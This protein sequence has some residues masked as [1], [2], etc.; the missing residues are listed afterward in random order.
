M[1]CI[2]RLFKNMGRVISEDTKE[3]TL[4]EQWE[5]KKKLLYFDALI[6]LI[7][8]TELFLICLTILI[9]VTK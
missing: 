9:S 1:R 7:P 6:E 3:Y 8:L 5:T 4:S 2:K